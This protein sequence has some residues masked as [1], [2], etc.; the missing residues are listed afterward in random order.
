MEDNNSQNATETTNMPSGSP[1]FDLPAGSDSR[2]GELPINSPPFNEAEW[3]KLIFMLSDTQGW[4][5]KLIT[6]ALLQA[7]FKERKKLYRR[8]YHLPVTSLAHILE[9][10]YYKILRNP[11]SSKF[12]IPVIEI[13]SFLRLGYETE[14]TPIPGTLHYQRIIDAG[15]IIGLD[16]LNAPI[17]TIVIVTDA[18]GKIITAYPGHCYNVTPYL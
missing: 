3:I 17:T 8:T 6:T 4:L 18:G 13:L 7:Q 5:N 14:A 11:G 10:H 1:A 9:R 16:R 12:T 2:Q 15:K